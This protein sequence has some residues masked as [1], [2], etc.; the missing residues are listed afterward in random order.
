MKTCKTYY[1]WGFAILAGFYWL[2][3]LITPV[4][5]G[6]T[7]L[8]SMCR[9]RICQKFDP[10][11]WSNSGLIKDGK[12]GKFSPSFGKRYEMV[13]DLLESH[14]VVGMGSNQVKELIGEPDAGVIDKKYF[15]DSRNPYCGDRQNF[16][17]EILESSNSI[18]IWAYHLAHQRQYPARSILFP[19]LF[20]NGDEWK[21]IIEMRNSKVHRI[22]V[23]R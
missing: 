7:K 18:S 5:I 6:V 4:F 15:L 14:V 1:L 11:L 22:N 13:D 23:E 17:K 2:N 20:F 19:N 10:L 16:V 12:H 21:L 3:Y 9:P 8:E